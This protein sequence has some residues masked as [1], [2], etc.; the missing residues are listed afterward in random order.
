M[1][2]QKAIF[3]ETKVR[4]YPKGEAFRV[5]IFLKIKETL[6]KP[7]CGFLLHKMLFIT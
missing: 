3:Y 5:D 4:L 7:R 2:I 1:K 6:S